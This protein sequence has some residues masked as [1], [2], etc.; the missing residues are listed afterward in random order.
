MRLDLHIDLQNRV[1][2]PDPET[3]GA[4]ALNF[5]QGD[6]YEVV[7]HGWRPVTN[8]ASFALY[9]AASIA[10]HTLAAGVLL[11]DAAP[12]GG[13]FKVKIGDD[14][15]AALD[16]DISKTALAVA[17]NALASV[18]AAGGLTI[19]ED[20]P[21]HFY[22]V[23]WTIPDNAIEIEFPIDD[24]KLTP[25]CIPQVRVDE[26]I[27]GKVNLK[28]VRAPVAFTNQ[29]ALPAPPAVTVTR[30]R[31]GSA[32]RNEVQRLTIPAAAVGSFA[33]ASGKVLPV[34]TVTASAIADSLNAQYTALDAADIR[35]V[36]TARDRG[37]FDI[38]FIGAF[39]QTA[40]DLT[41]VEMFDQV[42]ID[43]PTASLPFTSTAIEDVLAGARNIPMVFEI[44]AADE[45]GAEDTIVQQACTLINDGLSAGVAAYIAAVATRT[46]TVYVYP[47]ETDPVAIGLLG[48]KFSTPALA[49]DFVYTHDFNTREVE[50]VVLEKIAD[51]PD[52]FRQVMDDEF[53]VDVI[54]A[55]QVQVWFGKE[56]PASPAL[57]SMNVWVRSLNAMPILNAHRHPTDQVDG[58]GARDGQTL[59]EIIEELYNS[60]PADWPNIPA[61]KI[62]GSLLWSQLGGLIPDAKIP[63]NIPRLNAGGYLDISTIPLTVPR[64]DSETGELVYWGL[65]TETG[66]LERRVL[67]D[68][69][70]LLNADRFGDLSRIPG[71]A[72]AVKKVLSGDAAND[73]ALTFALPS[74]LELYPGRATAV[75][76]TLD[77]TVLPTSGTLIPAVRSATATN[78]EMI[79]SLD[80]ATLPRP[81]GLLPAIHDATI[82]NLTIPIPAPGA[83]YTGNVYLNASGAE[84]SLSG[85]MGRKG[86]KLKAG[87]HAVCDGRLWYR[88]AREGTTTS[89]HPT[90]FERELLMLDVNGSMFPVGSLFTLQLDFET[91]II[92]S[93]TRAQWV[94]I[95]EIG[96]FAA[97][98]GG[99]GT[100]ISGITWGATPVISCPMHLTS[101]RTPHTFGVRFTCGSATI[102]GETKLYR[103]A[104]ATTAVVPAG[105]GFAVRARL[106]RF[107]TED[108]LAD[109]RG[110]VFLAFNPHKK[111]LATIV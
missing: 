2:I 44:V 65:N 106:A 28:L 76:G 99:A 60:L 93:E 17:L 16:W 23:Q 74:Y 90:D 83:P 20:G 81:G 97:V 7:L 67:A 77:A 101:I 78:K 51:A 57:G 13:T 84:V 37:L 12:K 64:L 24:N 104:W 61:S 40:K 25:L 71:F 59:T 72:D 4:V 14:S 55:N 43:S 39:A 95:V 102:A 70:G 89:Y 107:D 3:R 62:I 54:N 110:Y 5:M 86:S 32:L 96:A 11:I 31:A 9:E 109:P 29:F 22:I 45:A 19:L 87:E 69:D 30:V 41:A 111:S 49:E 75:A 66:E 26:A 85:G 68:A 92:R 53:E 34:S 46:D 79:G 6:T 42:A 88:V 98:A 48:Q 47:L 35:Y 80:A 56:I 108:S 1:L 91:Q 100:N 38:E 58:V 27:S 8:S 15:T 10:W 50:V 21:E 105:P 94:L 82:A 33:L 103:G 18:T 63:V 52:K 73:L 36:V